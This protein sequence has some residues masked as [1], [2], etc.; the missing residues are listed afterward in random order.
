MHPGRIRSSP[1]LDSR[2]EQ[3]LRSSVKRPR[4]KACECDTGIINESKKF[5]EEYK[6]T[7]TL[8]AGLLRLATPANVM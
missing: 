1:R 7:D 6:A 2:L 3:I 8:D 5:G 4:G